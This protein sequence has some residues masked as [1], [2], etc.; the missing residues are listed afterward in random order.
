MRARNVDTKQVAV[1]LGRS[2]RAVKAR[3]DLMEHGQLGDARPRSEQRR[4]SGAAFFLS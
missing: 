3:L 2:E 4:R 1:A